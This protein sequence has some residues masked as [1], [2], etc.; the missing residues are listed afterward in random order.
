MHF[1][2]AVA[3]RRA[4]CDGDNDDCQDWPSHLYTHARMQYAESKSGAL[5]FRCA[6]SE[7]DRSMYGGCVQ[8]T[9][10][11]VNMRSTPA[12]ADRRTC[13]RVARN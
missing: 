10:I 4:R 8:T 7:C 9:D 13:M 1:E 2:Y 3:S 12:A 5:T 11:V 6:V